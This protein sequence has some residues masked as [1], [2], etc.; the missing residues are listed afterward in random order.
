[1][2]LVGFRK[3]KSI[4]EVVGEG[5]GVGEWVR[6]IGEKM[7]RRFD[8]NAVHAGM[9]FSN[10]KKDC[11]KYKKLGEMASQLRTLVAL[12]EDPGLIPSTHTTVHNCL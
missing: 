6:G 5:G 3:K 2:D 9:K 11:L 4:W 1:V 12:P 8:L 7:W 10:N